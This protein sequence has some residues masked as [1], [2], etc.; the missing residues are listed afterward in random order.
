MRFQLIITM[1]EFAGLKVSNAFKLD[2]HQITQH[3]QMAEV[4]RAEGYTI[5]SVRDYVIALLEFVQSQLSSDEND[6]RKKIT[7]QSA[8]I[9]SLVAEN[10]RLHDSSV[11]SSKELN[12]ENSNL[13][14]ELRLLEIKVASATETPV[15]AIVFKEENLAL[16]S[17]FTEKIKTVNADITEETAVISAISILKDMQRKGDFD[18]QVS[19]KRVKF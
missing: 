17:D 3:N 15:N 9:A 18:F 14:E 5:D 19:G 4:L 1:S 13:R 6:L 11:E 16:V 7:E 2:N 12:I 8:R 10:E